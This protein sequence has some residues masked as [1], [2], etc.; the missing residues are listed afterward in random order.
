MKDI[1]FL[2]ELKT[3]EKWAE[4]FECDGEC[5]L[6]PPHKMCRECIASE[7]LNSIGDILAAALEEGNP[8]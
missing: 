1:M 3:L 5:D 8:S 2:K 7:A 6:Q 4:S